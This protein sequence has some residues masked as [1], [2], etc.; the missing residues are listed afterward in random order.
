MTTPPI[1]APAVGAP[2][3]LPSSVRALAKARATLAAT[4]A[5]IAAIK[6]EYLAA[7][8]ELF[9][10]HDAEEQAVD[11]AQSV[12]KALALEAFARL[13]TKKL[14]A[15]V[16]IAMA[17][18]YAID[19]AAG[20]AWARETRRCLIPEALD[21]KMVKKLVAIEPLPFATVSEAPSVRIASD[22]SALL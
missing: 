3:D 1:T 21:V 8:A 20:L 12:V 4:D 10:Q 16:E 2:V 11:D 19:E 22:L 13:R 14:T 9:A 18:E 17:K 7:N 15:G 6:A 5:T